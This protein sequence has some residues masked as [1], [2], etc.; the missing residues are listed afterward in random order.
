MISKVAFDS[1][2]EMV[3]KNYI[4][5]GWRYAKSNHWMTKKD[6]KFTYKIYFY[7]NWHNISDVDVTFYG[8]GQIISTKSK[9]LIYYTTTGDSNVPPTV[10]QWNVAKKKIGIMHVWSL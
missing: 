6:K 1:V 8:S 5:K 9:K 4:N 10:L 7:T 3:A 2:C